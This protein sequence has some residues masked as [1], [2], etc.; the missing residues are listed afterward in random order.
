MYNRRLLIL[1]DVKSIIIKYEAEIKY[2]YEELSRH[3]E[4]LTDENIF[5]EL[6]IELIQKLPFDDLKILFNCHK[7]DPEID[8][9]Q[10]I[11]GSKGYTNSDYLKFLKNLKYDRVKLFEIHVDISN[12]K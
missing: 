2:K 5:R 10:H 8:I 11:R 6:I 4:I 1:D 12:N 9:A 3:A 7:F